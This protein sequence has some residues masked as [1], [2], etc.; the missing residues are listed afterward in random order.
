MHKVLVISGTQIVS[1]AEYVLG[2]FLKDTKYKEY[3]KILHS[4]VGKVNEFYKEFKVNYIYKSKYLKPVGAVNNKFNLIKKLYNL[5]GSF[6]IFYKI[7][8]DKNIKVVLGNN[9]G[10][11]I[12][13]FYY[14]LF[15]KKHIN[16]IHDMIEPNSMIA[17]SI[18]F[19]DRFIYKYIAVSEAVKKA[20]VNIG[21][22]E[23][24]IEVVYNGVKYND[25]INYKEFKDSITFGFVG[26]IENNKNPLEFLKF[27]EVMQQDIK[28]KAILGKM[29][30]GNILDEEL[31]KAMKEYIKTKKLNVELIGKIVK[32]NMS[33]FYDS[34]NFLLLTSKKDSLPT[35]IL[36]A[37]NSAVPVIGHNVDG[38]PEMIESGYNGF[39]YNSS[40]DFEKIFKNLLSYDYNK[41]QKNANITIKEK[42]NNLEKVKRLEN[43]L[44]EWGRF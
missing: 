32:N 9:T 12:Y 40:N 33:H 2:D 29:V 19:F 6:F 17:K 31:Y 7:F 22:S 20:L 5:L 24:K 27:I 35:V 34:I 36:E 11:V 38:I 39:L 44:F 26:N 15:K 42:F 43:E 41:L 3:I 4:D 14:Y 13:S 1:G 25:T 28:D 10:D 37:F 23:D 18:L 30:Y 8:K 21:I 16:Y